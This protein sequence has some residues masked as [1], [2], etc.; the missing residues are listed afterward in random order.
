MTASLNLMRSGAR[1]Q[2]KQNQKQNASSELK[3][4]RN[5]GA[6]ILPPSIWLGGGIASK[7]FFSKSAAAAPD[8]L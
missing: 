2:W 3:L 8:Q 7:I 5:A 1:S 6:P 4:H